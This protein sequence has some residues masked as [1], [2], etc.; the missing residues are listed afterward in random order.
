MLY[1]YCDTLEGVCCA[2]RSR[3]CDAKT[4]LPKTQTHTD[5]TVRPL[6]V[7]LSTATYTRAVCCVTHITTTADVA[8]A[9]AG[10]GD[11]S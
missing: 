11:V 3:R 1:R 8:A 5:C 7:V 2:V 10:V 9:A 6:A 4:S